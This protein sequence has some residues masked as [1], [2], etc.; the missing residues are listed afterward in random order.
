MTSGNAPTGPKVPV[1]ATTTGT[2]WFVTNPRGLAAHQKPVLILAARCNGRMRYQPRFGKRAGRHAMRDAGD[3]LVTAAS[4]IDSFGKTFGA[5]NSGNI[6][7]GPPRAKGRIGR[8]KL[9]RSMS[10]FHP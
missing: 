7:L 6:R 2:S 10:R 8:R 5:S 9:P 1:V 4:G 3:K